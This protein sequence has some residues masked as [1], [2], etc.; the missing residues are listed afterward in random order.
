MYSL[1]SLPLAPYSKLDVQRNN[2]YQVLQWLP[3]E[4]RFK[5]N[6]LLWLKGPQSALPLHWC[7]SF[8]LTELQLHLPSYFP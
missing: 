4:I 3:V 2:R 8:S 5:T 6:S 7:L 1:F